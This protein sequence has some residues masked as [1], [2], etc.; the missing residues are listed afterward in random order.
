[1]TRWQ[2]T[3]IRFVDLEDEFDYPINT[4]SCNEEKIH[5]KTRQPFDQIVGLPIIQ[6]GKNVNRNKLPVILQWEESICPGTIEMKI[7]KWFE[8]MSSTE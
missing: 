6:S 7:E 1:M 8:L 5:D 3:T 4:F 2:R